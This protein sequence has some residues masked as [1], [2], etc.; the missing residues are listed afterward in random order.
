MEA[1]EQAK[2]FDPKKIPPTA[3]AI[4]SYPMGT[5]HENL[6]DMRLPMVAIPLALGAFLG[7]LV[8]AGVIAF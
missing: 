6:E 4:S 7:L 8:L 3:G 5:S 1:Q 2:P